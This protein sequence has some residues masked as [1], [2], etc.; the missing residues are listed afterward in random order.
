[1]RDA[2]SRRRIDSSRSNSSLVDNDSCYSSR[3]CCTA[4]VAISTDPGANA[5]SNVAEIAT[6]LD[7]V[8]ARALVDVVKRSF[9]S[10]ASRLDNV[11]CVSVALAANVAVRPGCGSS[12]CYSD[13][14]SSRCHYVD[15]AAAPVDVDHP[16]AVVATDLAVDCCFDCAIVRHDESGHYVLVPDAVAV[17]DVAAIRDAVVHPVDRRR[18]FVAHDVAAQDVPV[19]VDGPD[20]NADHGLVTVA[21]VP[22]V[23]VRNVAGAPG[24]VVP[25]SDVPA[26][27][28]VG[29]PDFDDPALVVAVPNVVAVVAAVV[30]PVRHCVAAGVERLDVLLACFVVV[31]ARLDFP[32][33]ALLHDR[34]DPGHWQHQLSSATK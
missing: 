1:M 34:D 26:P 3:C 20:A 19:V 23:A 24:F 27:V 8:V 33:S 32:G 22:A 30:V 21:V 15:C 10:A 4:T 11:R 29:V 7:D 2:A 6:D 12:R 28:A 9:A 25:G 17:R 18:V 31:R 14:D 5:H 16:A 13:C